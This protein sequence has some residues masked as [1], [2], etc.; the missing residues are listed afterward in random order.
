ME[1]DSLVVADTN[2]FLDLISVDLLANFCALPWRI[3]TNSHVINEIL[4]PRESQAI[5][6]MIE[7]GKIDVASLGPKEIDRI[8]LLLGSNGALSF[9]D[10]SVLFEAE[11]LQ[12]RLLTSDRS[13]RLAAQKRSIRVSGLLFILDQFCGTGLVAPNTLARKLE[14]LLSVNKRLPEGECGKRIL[15]WSK[16]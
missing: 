5:R 2:I 7:R 8:L 4:R 1:L 11:Q 6:R 15:A 12:A 10:C 14:E 3:H 16:R 13:L 9:T